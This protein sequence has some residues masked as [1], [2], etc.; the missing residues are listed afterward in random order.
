M[1]LSVLQNFNESDLRLSPYPHIILIDALEKNLAYQLTEEFP[2][3]EFSLD[4]N[5]LR[6]DI[7]TCKI[8]NLS[9]IPPIWADFINYHS[10]ELFYKEVLEAFKGALT[11]EDF[12]NY[13]RYQTGIRGID[14]H[15]PN[16]ILLD[17]QISIN[18]PVSIDS[19]VR[20]AHV[21][22]TNKLFSGLFYLRKPNDDSSGGNL[23]LCEWDRSYDLKKKINL[24]KENLDNKHY[25]IVQEVKYENNVVILFLN[26]I[27]ALHLVTP[28][29]KT[30]HPR[31]FVNLVGEVKDDI[32]YKHNIYRRGALKIR[33]FLRNA[34][35]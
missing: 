11:K 21:D 15:K 17:A 6:K 19:S 12:N 9:T 8:G 30:L 26:S 10:S 14:S 29:S 35:S 4:G 16:H 23:R 28:R 13:Y 3:N 33:D 18:T 24:Y 34:L 2:L 32:F 1:N 20:K 31:C 27:D 5:N 7:S 25:E 22:N